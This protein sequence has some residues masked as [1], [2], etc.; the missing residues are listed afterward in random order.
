MLTPTYWHVIDEET[1]ETVC[2][3]TTAAAAF[4][5]KAF[6]AR[7]GRPWCSINTGTHVDL[8]VMVGES[9]CY[10]G[11]LLSVEDVA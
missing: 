6:E 3:C 5:R 2:T 9:Y 11:Q 7:N 8:T 10:P 1:N 4:T